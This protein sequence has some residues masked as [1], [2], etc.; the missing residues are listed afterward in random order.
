MTIVAVLLLS[1]VICAMDVPQ[2]KPVT[3][4][5]EANRAVTCLS[6]HF[7]T[8]QTYLKPRIEEAATKVDP[9]MRSLR[10]SLKDTDESSSSS[11][12]SDDEPD[13]KITEVKLM[14]KLLSDTSTIIEALLSAEE[15]ID[16]LELG[17]ASLGCLKAEIM[18]TVSD[19]N[20]I[21]LKLSVEYPYDFGLHASIVKM[22]KSAV[23]NVSAHLDTI[24]TL[25]KVME[26][27]IL[28]FKK[29]K[30]FLL[31]RTE[32]L[33]AL[34]DVCDSTVSGL[35]DEIVHHL[36]K[37]SEDPASFTSKASGA[38]NEMIELYQG[39]YENYIHM[40]KQ[41]IRIHG[42]WPELCDRPSIV[43]LKPK[44]K[45]FKDDFIRLRREYMVRHKLFIE[46]TCLDIN[47]AE[48]VMEFHRSEHQFYCNLK[49][50]NRDA[51][52][53]KSLYTEHVHP[54]II[55]KEIELV[56][57]KDVHMSEKDIL[58]V[59]FSGCPHDANVKVVPKPNHIFSPCLNI[60]ERQEYREQLVLSKPAYNIKGLRVL[61]TEIHSQVV[62]AIKLGASD[63]ALHK[64]GCSKCGVNREQVAGLYQEAC[65]IFA[66]KGLKRIYIQD[67]KLAKQLKPVHVR[68]KH[69]KVS[70]YMNIEDCLIM[71]PR[72]CPHESKQF[73][74]SNN[75]RCHISPP[76][77]LTEDV[78]ARKSGAKTLAFNTKA[79]R[80]MRGIVQDQFLLAQSRKA[81]MLV[82][83]GFGCEQCGGNLDQIAHLYAEAVLL[84]RDRGLKKIV[85]CTSE[86][87]K[88]VEA[89]YDRIA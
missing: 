27:Y 4:T 59:N 5:D 12:W 46:P 71:N 47:S 21:N 25:I 43:F 51:M 17:F 83:G 23:V 36:K 8:L 62:K 82:I 56:I 81:S 74:A 1:A 28:S 42:L 22:T 50:G 61:R 77:N 54:S 31:K 30:A 85:I 45:R 89:E 7:T 75:G 15:Q 20:M 73:R 39:E 65:L 86:L 49:K 76:L 69:G 78:K 11:S 38:L 57:G 60:I 40:R 52:L 2:M 79:M 64:F 48:Y 67:K 84:F 10:R 35:D 87:Y 18:T 29:G 3:I 44:V 55:A 19:I 26:D 72:G 34:Y 68:I 63:L 13:E 32:K 6:D 37:L 58:H 70:D 9:T 33:V 66:G 88:L 80:V 41:L 16:Q 24:D 14:R 53:D